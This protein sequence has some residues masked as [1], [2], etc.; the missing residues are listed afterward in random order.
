MIA[1]FRVLLMSGFFLPLALTSC[2]EAETTKDATESDT[3]SVNG[4]SPS[5]ASKSAEIAK[6]PQISD[7]VSAFDAS[8]ESASAVEATAFDSVTTLNLA[9]TADT[10]L[11]FGA[12]PSSLQSAFANASNPSETYCLSLNTAMLALANVVESDLNL[13]MLKGSLG[14]SYDKKSAEYQYADV[15]MEED[16]EVITSNYK[17]KLA[18]DDDGKVESFE[19]F[20]CESVDGEESFQIGYQKVTRSGDKLTIASRAFGDED[21]LKLRI[22]TRPCSRC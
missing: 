6:V 1:T 13:C 15:E 18:V 17:Y 22:A 4:D 2:T 11:K 16:G 5:A 3:S 14:D 8:D 7:P 9:A 21:G 12:T 20:V 19:A 10:G